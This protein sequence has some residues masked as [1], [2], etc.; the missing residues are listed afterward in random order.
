MDAPEPARREIWRRVWPSLAAIGAVAVVV[1]IAFALSQNQG[2]TS[3]GGF[4]YAHFAEDSFSF[5][6]PDDWKVI[7]GFHHYGLH[8]PAVLA[9]VGI[10][11]FDLGCRE[12]A[13]S[14]SCDGAPHWTVPADGI[15]LAYRFGAY[16]PSHPQPTP[17]LAPGDEWVEVGG[18]GAILSRTSTSMTW[19]FPGAPEFI[20]AR[21]GLDAAQVAP[22]RIEMVI[23]TWHFDS[24][25]PQS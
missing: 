17:S 24:P 25:P 20:E 16:L 6:Y 11:G 19:H 8:G 13:N 14:V 4:H 7:S 10:G 2:Y 1:L 5:D 21:W 22:G 15:V 3:G 18:R 9:A 23:S 12:T